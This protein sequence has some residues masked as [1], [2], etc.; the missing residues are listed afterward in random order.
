MLQGKIVSDAIKPAAQMS[1]RQIAHEVPIERQKNILRD[2]FN[3]MVRHAESGYVACERITAR[4]KKLKDFK[5]DFGPWTKFL[6]A[7]MPQA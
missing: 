7:R 2:I 4:I 3:V 6:S 1:A 5:F